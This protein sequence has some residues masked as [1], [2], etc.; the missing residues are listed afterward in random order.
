MTVRVL[1]VMSLTF[2]Q[3]FCS[4]GRQ[5]STIPHLHTTLHTA[6]HVLIPNQRTLSPSSEPLKL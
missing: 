3:S 4:L 1:V 6:E 5:L 2:I